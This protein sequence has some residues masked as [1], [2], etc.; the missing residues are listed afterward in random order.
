MTVETSAQTNLS[1]VT[2]VQYDISRDFADSMF[3]SCKDVQ[4]GTGGQAL[5]LMCGKLKP[6]ETCKVEQ[7]LG[8]MGTR[9]P[10]MGIPTDI[11][12]IYHNVSTIYLFIRCSLS[13][14]L[15]F[16]LSLCLFLISHFRARP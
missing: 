9:N 11:D 8:F 10:A 14:Y 16:P 15:S 6:N 13:L 4:L 2:K 1:Y 5:K 7:W 12:Y 3:N